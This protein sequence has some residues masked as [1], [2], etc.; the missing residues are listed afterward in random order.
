ME[1]QLHADRVIPGQSE[2]IRS[3]I[4]FQVMLDVPMVQD[5][6]GSNPGCE[7]SPVLT[8]LKDRNKSG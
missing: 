2:V 3:T 6:G 1:S 8:V 7:A 4:F 5:T